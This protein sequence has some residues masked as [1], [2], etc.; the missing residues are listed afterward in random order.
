MRFSIG[1]E[2]A[3]GYIEDEMGVGVSQ[4]F[5]G[6]LIRLDRNDII[7]LSQGV[8]YGQNGFVRITFRQQIRRRFFIVPLHGNVLTRQ[9]ADHS[10]HA[11]F[12]TVY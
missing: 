11:V 4:A 8:V 9:P 5:V 7:S 1:A 6:I 12:G 10:G 3:F 2:Y